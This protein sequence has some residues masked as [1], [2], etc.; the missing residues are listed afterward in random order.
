[1]RIYGTMYNDVLLAIPFFTFMGLIL[2]RSGMME[3]CSTQMAA[4][5]EKPC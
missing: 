2:E 1:M 5:D 4:Y 3:A